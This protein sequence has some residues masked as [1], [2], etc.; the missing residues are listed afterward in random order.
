MSTLALSGRTLTSVDLKVYSLWAL[1]NSENKL[2]RNRSQFALVVVRCFK[3][4]LSK[5]S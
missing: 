1:L 5:Q 4:Y 2:V 3:T